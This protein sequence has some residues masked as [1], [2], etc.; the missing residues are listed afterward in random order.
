LK[1]KFRISAFHFANNEEQKT[2][3]EMK[4]ETCQKDNQHYTQ[5][6]RHTVA[7]QARI[8]RHLAQANIVGAIVRRRGKYTQ[9]DRHAVSFCQMAILT[10]HEV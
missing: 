3:I 1:A 10:L 5:G 8:P 2:K 9:G 7:Q 4:L 6:D